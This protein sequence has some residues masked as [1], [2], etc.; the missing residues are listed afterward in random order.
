MTVSPQEVT[1]LLI[2]WSNGE[3]SAFDK[4]MTLIYPELRRIAK[5]HMSRQKPEHTLQTTGL[6]NEAYIKLVN[7][8]QMQWQNRG[9]FFAVAA[10]AM[11]Q[12]LV[13]YARSR[14]R[15]KRGGGATRVTLDHVDKISLQQNAELIALDEALATLAEV[16]LR[17]SQV[18]ELRFFG[19]LNEEEIAEVL[20][21]S[22]GTV[23][24]DWRL[25]KIWLLRELM[26]Q[27]QED[28][29]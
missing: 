2:A 23:K 6:I 3:Q 8:K 14:N 28:E 20:D 26:K 7:Q 4:L 1:Q 21:V 25:A 15:G 10:K 24:R 12:I 22:V 11:R 27:G 9:H 18:V 19:G 29:F 13:D 5:R 17:K 16:D